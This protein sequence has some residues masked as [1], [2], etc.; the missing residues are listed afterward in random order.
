MYVEISVID[1]KNPF[2]RHSD[3]LPFVRVRTCALTGL[4]DFFPTSSYSRSR[5]S[6]TKLI[7]TNTKDTWDM[8]LEV[9]LIFYKLHEEG[10][11][12][13]FPC[14]YYNTNPLYIL[15]NTICLLRMFTL[16]IT[17]LI[18]INQLRRLGRD[19]AIHWNG[20]ATAVGV[21]ILGHNISTKKI[22]VPTSKS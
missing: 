8:Y 15:T 12:I 17:V 19:C 6:S 20:P 18:F 13:F 4:D 11:G 7:L 5:F 2:Y 14:N 22:C 3:S 16:W 21:W 9:S 10:N 1:Y